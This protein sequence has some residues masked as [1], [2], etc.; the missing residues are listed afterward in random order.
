MITS[1]FAKTI[2]I[3]AARYQPYADS[4]ARLPQDQRAIDFEKEPDAASLSRFMVMPPFDIFSDF[5]MNKDV[6]AGVNP[7]LINI[8]HA[9]AFTII[10]QTYQRLWQ[11]A[12]RSPDWVN[13]LEI[14][15]GSLADPHFFIDFCTASRKDDIPNTSLD[16]RLLPFL[17]DLETIEYAPKTQVYPAKTLVEKSFSVPLDE[18]PRFVVKKEELRAGVMWYT[19]LRIQGNQEIITPWRLDSV[20]PPLLKRN[21]TSY[22]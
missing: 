1:N 3:L 8:Y 11:F 22:T 14:S 16:Q 20:E 2:Q 19:L 4:L 18:E 10:P 12:R 7:T 5:F 17:N 9:Q 21:P 15:S 6:E 13:L